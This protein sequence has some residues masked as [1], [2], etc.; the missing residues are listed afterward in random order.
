[1]KAD[2][3]IVKKLLNEKATFL[4]NEETVDYLTNGKVYVSMDVLTDIMYRST[5][6]RDNLKDSDIAYL[7][8]HSL[9]LEEQCKKLFDIPDYITVAKHTITIDQ[10]EFLE[11]IVGIIKGEDHELIDRGI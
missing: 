2:I 9:R 3:R 5:N 4:W 6:E 10:K 1:M 11:E 7:F 8:Y